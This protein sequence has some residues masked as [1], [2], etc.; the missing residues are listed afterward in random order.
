MQIA[1]SPTRTQFPLSTKKVLKKTIVGSIV[2]IVL[3]G[4]F[5]SF[6]GPMAFILSMDPGL[7]AIVGSLFFIITLF[8]VYSGFLFIFAQGNESKLT[9]AKRN[10]VYVVI[11]ALLILG[12]WVIATLI[13]VTVS[14]LVSS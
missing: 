6:A 1:T 3:F 14:Q 8:F 9:E 13:G 7:R 4:F 12:A 5:V 10:F 11:G 2:W